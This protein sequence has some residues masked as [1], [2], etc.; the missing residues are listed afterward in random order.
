MGA[1]IGS[2]VHQA[3]ITDRLYFLMK[4]VYDLLVEVGR[5]IPGPLKEVVDSGNLEIESPIKTPASFNCDIVYTIL[6]IG[7]VLVN[8]HVLPG[9]GLPFLPR[10][11]LQLHLPGGFEQFAWYGRGPHETYVD[12]KEGAPIGVYS[13]SVDEQFVPYIVPEEN[14]NKT[15][16][17]WVTLTNPQ[18]IGLQ[19]SGDRL[20][21]VSAHHFT[22]EDLTTAR[23]PHEL[24]RREEIILHLDYGQSGLGS[25][26]C[27]PG[28]LEKY[29]LQ[30]VEIRYRVRLRPFTMR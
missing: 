16:V 20:L 10:I 18:G 12:R 7:E 28:R 22:P 4:S 9:E 17:R 1:K 19:A 26:S 2:L 25:A 24:K 13:G 8:T 23:H 11:G 15:D 5:P 27:G 6:G 21:E 3:A 14:G 30:P 29:K